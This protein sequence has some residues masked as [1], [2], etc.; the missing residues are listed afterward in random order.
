MTIQI[1]VGTLVSVINIMVHA[2]TTVAAIGMARSAGLRMS[3]WPKLHLMGV[4]GA[5]ASVLLAAHMLE[6][7]VWSLVYW[8]LGV[9][10]NGADLMDFAF[11]N[12]T[13]LGYGDVTPVKAWRLLG[14][15]TAMNGVLMFG[16]STA[17]LFEVLL[18]T[19]ERYWSFPSS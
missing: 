9:A 1:V 6:V 17:V 2:L 15:M 18:K 16:W 3:S 14:P 5:T 10:P 13:T 8:S 11:V 12:Y 19:I 7:F 4:M